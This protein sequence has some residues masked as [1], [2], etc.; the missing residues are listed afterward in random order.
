MRPQTETLRAY[1]AAA[2]AAAAH[3]VAVWPSRWTIEQRHWP[4]S[5]SGPL[6]QQKQRKRKQEQEQLPESCE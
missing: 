6:Q 2:A 5:T 1:T 3:S 4:M